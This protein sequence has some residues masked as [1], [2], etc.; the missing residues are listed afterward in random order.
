MVYIII[1]RLNTG[2]IAAAGSKEDSW[3]ADRDYKLREV[4]ITERGA[5]ALDNVQFYAEKAGVPMFRPDIPAALLK[6]TGVDRPMLNLELTK[7][8]SFL[9][10]M[11]NGTAAAI[12]CDISLVLE[13]PTWPPT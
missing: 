4:L 12:N 13:L 8:Q 2:S 5:A 1:K 11:T 7:G 10:K 9:Y 6:P 3:A